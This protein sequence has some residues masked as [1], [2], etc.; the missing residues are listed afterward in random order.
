MNMPKKNL[1]ISRVMKRDSN[2]CGIHLA[3]GRANSHSLISSDYRCHE[4]QL[5]HQ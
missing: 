2:L 1:R 5:D 4:R 3:G